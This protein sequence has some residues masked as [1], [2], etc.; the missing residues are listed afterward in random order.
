MD[1]VEAPAMTGP[2][3]GGGVL[4]MARPEMRIS[5]GR[6]VDIGYIEPLF[7]RRSIIRYA[8]RLRNGAH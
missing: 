5:A 6:C 3:G 1:G 8:R 4:A 7:L 2:R